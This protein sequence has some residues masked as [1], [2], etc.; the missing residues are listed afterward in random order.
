[1]KGSLPATFEEKAIAFHF[2]WRNF[3][4][5]HLHRS[6]V[7]QTSG[8]FLVRL[9][10]ASYEIFALQK[11]MTLLLNFCNTALLYCALVPAPSF[12]E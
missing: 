1:M 11:E 9:E 10:F 7:F 12:L 6:N 8:E 3:E 4:C 2:E 5:D